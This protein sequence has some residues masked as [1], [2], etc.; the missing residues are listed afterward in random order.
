MLTAFE[1]FAEFTRSCVAFIEQAEGAF[2]IDLGPALYFTCPGCSAPLFYDYVDSQVVSMVDNESVPDATPH[3]ACVH[4][5]DR[6][7]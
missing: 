7:K 6:T 2:S 3:A 1:A 5:E 4:D